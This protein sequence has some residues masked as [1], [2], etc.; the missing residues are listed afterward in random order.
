[1]LQDA[2][3]QCSLWLY[4]VPKIELWKLWL[5]KLSL[6]QSCCGWLSLER[7]ASHLR[8]SVPFSSSSRDKLSCASRKVYCSVQRQTYL[9]SWRHRNCH[10]P[11]SEPWGHPGTSTVTAG[12]LGVP[13]GSVSLGV[14]RWKGD[15][16]GSGQRSLN[17]AS[18]QGFQ[19]TRVEQ[20][21]ALLFLARTD[22]LRSSRRKLQK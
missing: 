13:L 8:T 19:A 6:G 5:S 18:V 22:P 17:C 14:L 20:L 15:K 2:V 12:S 1:M 16:A 3:F 7:F 10:H 21:P 4:V 9:P 11:S